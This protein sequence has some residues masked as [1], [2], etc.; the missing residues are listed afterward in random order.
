M[1]AFVAELRHQIVTAGQ[2]LSQARQA[3]D[4]HAV[5]QHSARLLDLLDRAE[6][7]DVDTSDWVPASV[8]AAA[9]G[10]CA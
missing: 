5:H 2:T 8:V 4:D 1:T 9:A 3:E 10:N 7:T 6:A